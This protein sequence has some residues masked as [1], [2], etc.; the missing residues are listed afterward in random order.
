[1]SKPHP[2]SKITL[3]LG[4]ADLFGTTRLEY[5]L[6]IDYIFDWFGATLERRFRRYAVAIGLATIVW[7]VGLIISL[8]IGFA[9]DYI[10]T[11]AIYYFWIGIAWC[12]NA[13]RWLSQVYHVRT[14]EV[15]PCF[16][17]DDATYKLTVSP[18]AR[19]AVRN[20]RIFYKGTVYV[21][22]VLI[23]FGII[24]LKIITP[25]SF[26]AIGFP[27]S[28]P[29]YWLTG[30]FLLVKWIIIALLMWVTYIEAYTGVQL[31]LSTA[32]LYAKL[33]T[34]PVLPLPSLVNE[35][36][37]G[38]LNLYLTGAVM[39]SFGIVLVELLYNAH[40]DALG[41]GF[42]VVAIGLGIFAYLAPLAAVKTIW[43]KAKR[44]AIDNLVSTEF[45]GS[46]RPHDPDKLKGINEYIQ[47]LNDSEPGKFNIVQLVSFIAVQLLPVLPVIINTFSL[48]FDLVTKP[49]G[50]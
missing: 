11:P 36:F 26:L 7:G 32:P 48:G 13:L 2:K 39:W 27:P 16:P 43:R 44:Q 1:M 4:R 21:I 9:R 30:N 20:K 29:F 45:Y 35:L 8:T 3:D 22:P 12:S 24:M 46:D 17:V 19:E 14:N 23:Y 47:G 49:G 10:S 18:F 33:A 42:L 6:W 38:V 37:R 5:K 31:T 28:F 34:L 41:I 15:R 50:K 25:F 40:A